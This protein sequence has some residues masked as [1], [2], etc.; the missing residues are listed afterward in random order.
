MKT[1]TNNRIEKEFFEIKSEES[2]QLYNIYKTCVS[3]NR[4]REATITAI[5][6]FLQSSYD[7]SAQIADAVA[8]R[9]FDNFYSGSF[10][11]TLLDNIILASDQTASTERPSSP[12]AIVSL[13]DYK[14]FEEFIA[15]DTEATPSIK[16]LLLSFII[17][18]RL[19]YHP[20]GWIKYDK[21]NIFYLAGISKLSTAQQEKMTN[22][23]H[24]HY[25]LNM[26]VVGSNQPTTCYNMYWLQDQ[27]P[28]GSVNNPM[29]TL[30]KLTPE[31]IGKIVT[32]A[33]G[34]F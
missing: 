19:N 28:V 32:K 34:T 26:R 8:A 31:D 18:Y 12:D 6:S 11:E 7:I 4:G 13:E 27:P 14:K 1:I 30:G 23:L 2:K 24:S 15:A 21:K 3:D 10:Q 25:G 16:K 9:V 5:S 33:T 17:F 29:I 20:S 22:Y